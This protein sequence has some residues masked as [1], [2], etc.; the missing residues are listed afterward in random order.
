MREHAR[1][2]DDVAAGEHLPLAGVPAAIKD[3]MCL[4]GTRTTAGSKIL[5]H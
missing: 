3:N 4:T 1:R 5:E 2:I